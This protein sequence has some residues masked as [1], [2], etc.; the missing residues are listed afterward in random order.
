[1]AHPRIKR[2]KTE[3]FEISTYGQTLGEF[4][5]SSGTEKAKSA[6][7]MVVVAVVAAAAAAAAAAVVVVVVVVVLVVVLVVT[8]KVVRN[9]KKV[10]LEQGHDTS[11]KCLQPLG[12]LQGH[13]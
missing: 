10:K 4:K 8:C 11:N 9:K 1:M 12:T 5:L 7:H 3:V 13:K 2:K 6:S